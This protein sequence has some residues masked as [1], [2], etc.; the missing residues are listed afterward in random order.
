MLMKI[1]GFFDSFIDYQNSFIT[2]LNRV[3]HL[4]ILLYYWEVYFKSILL[5]MHVYGYVVLNS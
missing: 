5:F 2:P 1:T 4:S 3:I